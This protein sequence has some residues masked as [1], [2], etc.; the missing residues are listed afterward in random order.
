VLEANGSAR[1]K[2][3]TLVYDRAGR[4]SAAPII[5]QLEDGRQFAA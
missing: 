1:V 3:A 5:G 4:I 2:G